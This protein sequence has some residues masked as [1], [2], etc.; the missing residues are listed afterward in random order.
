MQL[1]R[2][3]QA[4]EQALTN[5]RLALLV[6]LL[7]P[8]EEQFHG[9]DVV[10]ADGVQQGVGHLDPAL[11]Q[12]FDQLEALVLNRDDDRSPTQR[13]RAVDVELVRLVLELVDQTEIDR[14]SLN[15]S[16]IFHLAPFLY[17]DCFKLKSRRRV[18][19]AIFQ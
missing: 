12:H 11:E 16:Q 8:F 2:P 13:V 7:F 1:I 18:G 10:L 15:K 3:S 17:Y 4:T 14:I 19:W 6:V 9:F 5:V